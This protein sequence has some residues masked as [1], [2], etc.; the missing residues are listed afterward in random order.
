MNYK[1]LGDVADVL[2]PHPSHRAPKIKDGGY[3]F[4]GIGDI[5]EYG[6][7]D[8]EK[9]RPVSLET[10]LE[11]EDRYEITPLSIGYGRVATIGK[12][13]KL[14]S[15]KKLKYS[16][17]PTLAVINPKECIDGRYLYYYIKSDMFFNEASKYITG[18]TR[19]TLGIQHLR[20]LPILDIPIERQKRLANIL[21]LFDKKIQT[22]IELS[23]HLENLCQELYKNWFVDF[24]FLNPEGKPYKSSG[25]KMKESELGLIPFSFEVIN[26][27]DHLTF[28]R[29]VEPGS[30]NYED[31]KDDS[32]IKFYRVG[33]MID[34]S[35]IKFIQ[36]EFANN[37]LARYDDVLVS[38]D[39]AIGR[40]TT[41]IVGA[42][43]TGIRNIRSKKDLF[44]RE[45]IYVLF[46]TNQIVNTI[47]Q[48][49]NGTTILHASSSIKYLKTVYNKEV[50]FK[51][52]QTINPIVK[53]IRSIKN[54]NRN[55]MEMRDLL[56]NKLLEIELSKS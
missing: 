24:E 29:G 7:I 45:H 53:K 26:L 32:N 19:Q 2:D 35:K 33:D 25:G 13:I 49:A 14:K 52:E 55:L 51:F 18:T 56:N 30:R 1:R 20:N 15:R 9:A 50:V 4:A 23:S 38:F 22:N 37:R 27:D 3:P 44:S 5:D 42:Y 8:V 6:N 34:E 46:K 39:G 17:S 41:G 28:D 10:I 16:L 43:S 54:E 31:L 11:H 48:Y 36:P 47:N 21:E 40:I 12:V